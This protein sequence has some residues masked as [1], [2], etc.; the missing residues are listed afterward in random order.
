MSVYEIYV[1]K[2]SPFAQEAASVAAD[3]RLALQIRNIE[4]VRIVNRYFA[5]DIG[6]DDF[7]K[8]KNTVFSEPPV[9]II[10]EKIPAFDGA[11]FFALEFLPGQFDQRADSCAQCISLA[12]GKERPLIHSSKIFAVYGNIKD[13][14]FC[15]IKSYL[16]N[17]VESREASFEKPLS[18]HRDFLPPKEIE[19]ISG[20][21]NF[22]DS[23]LEEFRARMN[24]AT[25]LQDLRFCR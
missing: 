3:L 10:Y 22:T 2:K 23:A 18:L 9:D 1:E 11:R 12:T 17:P 21:I 25:D 7:E 16:I 13:D 4:K 5:Q 8:A 24:L 19:I 15:R 14:D 6:A 20:F